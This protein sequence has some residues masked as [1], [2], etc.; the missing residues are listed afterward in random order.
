MG[1]L[2]SSLTVSILA[3]STALIPTT[4]HAA[5]V[6]SRGA[7]VDAS[8]RAGSRI[9][10]T[11][12]S[13]L[14]NG[15]SSTTDFA[16]AYISG[17]PSN[18]PLHS[19]NFAIASAPSRIENSVAYFRILLTA[20]TSTGNYYVEAGISA[21]GTTRDYNSVCAT[22]C[23]TTSKGFK[24]GGQPSLLKFSSRDLRTSPSVSRNVGDLTPSGLALFD[25]NGYRTILSDTETIQLSAISMPAGSIPSFASGYE[26]QTAN[27]GSSQLS[28]TSSD[29]SG[30]GVY[31]FKVGNTY[32]GT[33]VFQGQL[34]N[35]NSLLSISSFVLST[36]TEVISGK[37]VQTLDNSYTSSLM[38][39]TGSDGKLYEWGTHKS[40]L[41][42]QANS[43]DLASKLN[44]K[45]TLIDFPHASTGSN[46]NFVSSIIRN[47]DGYS[48]TGTG[49][50]VLS[51]DGTLWGIGLSGIST[52]QNLSGNLEPVF[53]FNQGSNY[54][55][56]VSNNARLFLLA[57]G[58]TLT[59]D[60][61]WRF[62]IP[63]LTTIGNP[64]ITQI[65]FMNVPGV[66]LF[67]AS[68]GKLY[69]SGSNNFGELGQGNDTSTALGEVLIPSNRVISRI[70]AGS[71]YG[72][73]K[74]LDGSYW[75][76]GDNRAGQQGKLASEV[77]YSNTPR[78]LITPSNFEVVELIA[79][80]QLILLG[81]NRFYRSDSGQ[82]SLVSPI[83]AGLP[84]DA[85]LSSVSMSFFDTNSDIY[86]W[87]F[88]FSDTSGKVYQNGGPT[89]SCSSTSGRIRSDGQ[90][91]ER[92]FVDP[93]QT[94]SKLYIDATS[95]S[96]ISGAISVKV[97]TAF[98]I[99]AAN[100]RSRCY[101]TSEMKFAWDKDGDGTFE[102]SDTATVGD[103][104]YLGL[105]AS[106]NFTTP[107]RRNVSLGVTTP[108]AV[109][110][111]VP[112][113]VGV[114]PETRTALSALDTSTIAM[115][116]NGNTTI[117]ITKSGTVYAWGDNSYGQLGVSPSL[118]SRRN[119][120][121]SL[122]LPETVTPV[123]VSALGQSSLVVD[124]AGRV[125]GFGRGN[126]IDG[127]SNNYTVAKQVA[128]LQSVKVRSLKDN[129]VLT[130]DG[131]LLLWS[132][133]DRSLVTIPSLAGIYMRSFVFR[134]SSWGCGQNS[135]NP[136]YFFID[137]VDIDG[138]LWRIPLTSNYVPGDAE[139]HGIQNVTDIKGYGSRSVLTTAA[140][141]IYYSQTAF[142]AYGLV[143]K[144]AGSTLASVAPYG[145]DSNMIAMADTA[146]NVWTVSITQD[147]GIFQPGTWTRLTAIDSVRTSTSDTPTLFE[148]APTYIG[149]ASDR[150]F[151]SGYYYNTENGTC[152]NQSARLYSTGQFGSTFFTDSIAI[153]STI[154]YVGSGSAITFATGQTL[155]AQ[156]GDN[157]IFKLTNPRS[158]CF[159]GSSQLSASADLDGNGSYETSISPTNES[160]TYSFIITATAPN[161][162][163]RTYSFKVETPIGTSRIF[164]VNVGVYGS[165]I[166]NSVV[167]RTKV[168]NTG[169]ST[170]FAIGSDGYGYAWGGGMNFMNIISSTPPRTY[171][172][173]TKVELPNDPQV[174]DGATYVNW[175]YD[176]DFGLLV[177]DSSGKVWSWGTRR[178]MDVP[179]STY[180]VGN[181][182]TTPT[183]VMSL[184]SVVIRR[185]S[186][187]SS[188]YR[189]LALSDAG[190]VYQWDESNRTPTL[191]SGLAGIPIKNIWASSDLYAALSTNGELYTWSGYGYN[192]GRI[193]GSNA[194]CYWCSDPNVGLATVADPVADVSVGTAK[195][196]QINTVLTMTGKL[197][198]WGNFKSSQV[199]VPEQTTLPG[200][201]TPAAIGSNGSGLLV[202]ATDKTW[203]RQALDVNR[204]IVYYQVTYISSAISNTFSSFATGTGTGFVST[205]SN[206]YTLGYNNPGTCGAVGSLN[207]VMS[208]GQF[209]SVY[210][211]DSVVLDISG[212]EISRP[213]QDNFFTAT[214]SSRC[215][216]STGVSITADLTGQGTYSAPISSTTAEDGSSVTSRF[217]FNPSING[218]LTIRVKATTS[219]AVVAN[220]N[221]NT[222]VVPLP[223]AGRQIG[224]SINSGARYTN[225]SNVTLDLV[226]P[227]GVYK[228]Y[229]SNDGGFAPGTV[230]E[231]DLQTQIAW[232]LP[233]QA[234]IPLPSIVYARFG[235]S[236]SYF[237][238]DI[239][240]DAISPVLTFASAR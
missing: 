66:S 178:N 30:D 54:I 205:N 15:T 51:N 227:D 226:W 235:D 36:T 38:Y 221:Y 238:D 71:R 140:G 224:V 96:Q 136:N 112:F 127:T 120:P 72:A 27:I 135:T 166:N 29:T 4:V 90:F 86:G 209:G 81:T 186:I 97:N 154:A 119:I 85:I 182:P 64:T 164:T 5:N 147:S 149:F 23:R 129:F 102:T 145:I 232:V 218:A 170:S 171:L 173:P 222:L 8:G 65:A 70:Y 124:S 177:V 152:N 55:T 134:G 62:S 21:T 87:N 88:L 3:I 19:S 63:D 198:S 28:I 172:K 126:Y 114:E 195:S 223:P 106:F 20:G 77:P 184:S 75:S 130:T 91:G 153:G 89:G 214:A 189:A 37:T 116:S 237:F 104:G 179:A 216:G 40:G 217:K 203:W 233:P 199:Y 206:A 43:L 193:V 111:Q 57:D 53:T 162:G 204:N 165:T 12:M 108:D 176:E 50:Y 231:I 137:A 99:Q 59:R 239:I 49:I 200:G 80:S 131:R 188:G 47:R 61:N 167:A 212:N 16:W 18:T 41:I 44:I 156:G 175:D 113:V 67:L 93:V 24:V 76:W 84:A 46:R 202:F 230:T 163:R 107:G 240:L 109:T 150:I 92:W 133:N 32:S 168:F 138:N 60:E 103:T 73:V 121:M 74:M 118:Y 83:N 190:N 58:T 56:Q 225:S 158:S 155:A 48:G 39:A 22:S 180:T 185:I 142:C 7:Y 213:G 2:L 68:S 78:V 144:P 229:V 234:V 98:T 210:A 10:V 26:S 191:V 123:S 148:S 69:S 35:S 208:E 105:N 160:G 194:D 187:S 161:S 151:T 94:G 169:T 159:T 125:W 174:I 132:P 100:V 6:E 220:Q 25:S 192:L 141:E 211:D 146:K 1:R 122:A 157:L 13:K 183:Q 9:V 215:F 219:A 117:A 201:R 95:T 33:T 181:V 197:L 236:T 143:A 128:S 52:E 196:Y 45:P 11:V 207:R 228:I 34:S 17:G 110:L 82:W 14:P 79:E 115:S 139:L 42:D 31:R 101:Q